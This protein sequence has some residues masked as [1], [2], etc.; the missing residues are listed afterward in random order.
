MSTDNRR[1]QLLELSASLINTASERELALAARL[2]ANLETAAEAMAA[3]RA[4]PYVEGSQGQLRP[5]PGFTV[6]ARCDEI[7]SK[8]Y[9]Q[10]TAEQGELIANVGG[11]LRRTDPSVR[12]RAA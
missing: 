2:E 8:L 10:I 9:A 1:Q 5:H 4:E 12:L 3:A 6:A 11:E 7:A